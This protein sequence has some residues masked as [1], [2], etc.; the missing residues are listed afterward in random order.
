M[1][2]DS[3]MIPLLDNVDVAEEID[4][5]EPINQNGGAVPIAP[6]PYLGIDPHMYGLTG[7][8][9]YPMGTVGNI[10]FGMG[11]HHHAMGMFPH[12]HHAMG[13]GMGGVPP[14]AAVTLGYGDGALGPMTPRV[15]MYLNNAPSFKNSSTTT[16]FKSLVSDLIEDHPMSSLGLFPMFPHMFPPKRQNYHVQ[17]ADS[18]NN[19]PT[20]VT[21]K[22][23]KLTHVLY[24]R[25][26]TVEDSNGGTPVANQLETTLS[27]PGVAQA[28]VNNASGGQGWLTYQPNEVIA[29]SDNLATNYLILKSFV[30]EK[31]NGNPGNTRTTIQRY[32][33]NKDN[34]KDANRKALE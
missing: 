24:D 30:D 9:P 5:I 3:V 13:V 14:G 7:P 20:K 18:R 34:N 31:N 11:M 10:P 19:T 21:W 1:S 2:K 23:G 6:S 8:G 4:M 26:G 25:T 28:D 33:A 27:L 16:L 17:P 32:W 15:G 12:H 29:L 22:R